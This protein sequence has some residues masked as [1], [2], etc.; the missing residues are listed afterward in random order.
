MP[1]HSQFK[2]SL[3]VNEKARQRN[4]TAKSRVKTMI[5]KVETA[6][7]KDEAQEAFRK[8]VSVIDSTARK[9][10]I[11]KKTAARKKSNLSKLVANIS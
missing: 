5:K 8:A 6:Q 7:S 3:K 2:K 9:G 1:Q 4:V 11:K 10:I